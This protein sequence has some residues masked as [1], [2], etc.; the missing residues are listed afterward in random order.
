MRR[1]AVVEC[2]HCVLAPLSKAD[3]GVAG[4]VQEMLIHSAGHPLAAFAGPRSALRQQ[5][6]GLRTPK[7]LAGSGV[8][9]GV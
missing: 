8:A 1:I 9:N 5:E 3:E 7:A 6:H 2:S 4:S